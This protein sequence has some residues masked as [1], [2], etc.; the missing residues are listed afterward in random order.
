MTTTYGTTRVE[1]P[2]TQD[3]GKNWLLVWTMDY[4]GNVYSPVRPSVVYTAEPGYAA[5]TYTQLQSYKGGDW[6]EVMFTS[7]DKP[8]VRWVF[9]KADN[10]TN[11]PIVMNTLL[12]GGNPGTY[13]T[14]NVLYT[15]YLDTEKS[16]VPSGGTT[17]L[18]FEHNNNGSEALD[19]P[20]LG[21]NQLHIWSYGMYWGQIDAYSNYGGIMNQTTPHTGSGAGLGYTDKLLVYVR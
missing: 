17:P 11:L 13:M 4:T 10:S 5:Y 18:A 14:V 2:I 15:M 8:T 21:K 9:N 1:G 12:S 7:R 6:S 20:T 16:S 19:I 3:Y